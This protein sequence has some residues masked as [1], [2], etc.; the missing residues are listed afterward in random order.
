MSLLERNARTAAMAHR[1]SSNRTA[2]VFA[3]ETMTPT[4]S[5]SAGA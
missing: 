3:P 5:P 4:R 2:V 1:Q